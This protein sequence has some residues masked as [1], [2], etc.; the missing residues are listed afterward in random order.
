MNE[1]DIE[2]VHNSTEAQVGVLQSYKYGI[3]YHKVD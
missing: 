2:K 3:L 1:N